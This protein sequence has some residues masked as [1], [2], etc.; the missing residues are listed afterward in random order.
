MSEERDLLVEAAATA[1][2]QRDDR[3][4]IVP[5]PAWWDLTPA[6]R[7]LAFEAHL[8]SREIERVLDPG[9]LSQTARA[10]LARASGLGQ[11]G[12]EE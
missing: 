7:D 11:L 9:G 2:R 3:G 8:V 1:F 10:V 12:A 5:S 4:R 6:D